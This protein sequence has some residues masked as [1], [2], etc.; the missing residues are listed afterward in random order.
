[1]RSRQCWHI[2][3]IVDVVVVG[4]YLVGRRGDDLLSSPASSVMRITRSGDSGSP[5]RGS[6]ARHQHQHVDGSPSP[7][8]VCGT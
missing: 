5:R 7:L 3:Q 8:I 4:D 6:A 1:M 2:G